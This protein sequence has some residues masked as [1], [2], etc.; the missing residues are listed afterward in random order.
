MKG[1]RGWALLPFCLRFLLCMALFC[2]GD[3]FAQNSSH[4]VA[5]ADQL[6]WRGNWVNARLLY[7][8][9]EREL[10][11]PKTR[12]ARRARI[13]LIRSQMQSGSCGTLLGQI[14][15]E[16]TNPIL[17]T[18]TELKIRA[19]AYKG[20]IAHQCDLWAAREAWEQV[21]DL[22]RRRETRRGKAGHWES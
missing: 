7:E 22:A 6:A 15:R 13:G 9:A 2:Q 3:I 19:L 14:N 5:R 12:G 17:E 4:I 11:D 16:L 18:E 8:Q 1:F 10:S 21:L 20:E